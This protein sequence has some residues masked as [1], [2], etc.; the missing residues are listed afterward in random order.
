MLEAAVA[1]RDDLKEADA[2]RWADGYAFPKSLLTN[3]ASCLRS[4][5]LDFTTMVARRQK[6]MAS[7]RLNLSRATRLRDDNPA[8]A[9]MI[10]L[11]DGMKVHLP[12]H[13]VPNG[14]TDLS[15]LR[16]SYLSV[17]P[18]VNKILG[19]IVEQGLAILLSYDSAI[20]YVPRL[21]FCKAHWTP[22]KGKPS[23]R[24]LGDL[25]FVEGTP[26]NTPETAA[27][28]A[29]H[30]GEIVHPTIDQ[31]AA[32]ITNYFDSARRKCPD[33]TWERLLIWKMDLRGAYQLL[34]FHPS[35]VGLFAMRLSNDLV[36]L[37][38]VGIFGWAG[39]PA[40]FQ[41]VTRAVEWELASRLHGRATMY[42]DD[43][44]GVSLDTD[45][46]QDLQITRSVCTDLLGPEAVADDKTETGRRLDV[47]GYVIDLDLRRVSIARKNYLTALHGFLS[48]D[49][50]G[51]M[52]LRSAQ[53]LASWGS[54]Y[55]RICRVMRPFS[56]AL[57][58][59]TVGRTSPHASFK[60]SAE[61]RVTIQCWRALLC[62]IRQDEA[63]FTR[64]IFSFSPV[65]A[66]IVAEFDASLSGIGV[67]W[68]TVSQGAEETVGVC[69]LSTAFLQFAEDSSYQNLSEFLGA[70]IAVVGLVRLGCR[71]HSLKL[72][73]DSVTALT[74]AITERP[75]GVLVTN[76]AMAW[77]LLCV[78][79]EI[80]V[81]EIIHL[82]GALNQKCDRLSRM[83]CYEESSIN[84]E[85]SEMGLSGARI[86]PMQT[87]PAVQ[88]LLQC[89]DPSIATGT[90]A[91]F[92]SL[93]GRMRAAVTGVLHVPPSL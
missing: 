45:V 47:L 61:A 92:M 22:K 76:A 82:P 64:D 54:R 57:H 37:Q 32:M 30:Y 25:T 74:W 80:H 31:I 79:A 46:E 39:T 9:L 3:D 68:S 70:L 15:P 34:S 23:G 5:M 51:S 24:P 67:I 73:G 69:A 87:D 42:V 86:V 41:V 78:A 14:L 21:H 77:T 33:V 71:G 27:A 12:E 72:R 40:A 55:S 50:D 10:E 59:L 1:N 2:I 44:I 83:L 17:A 18:A 53:R 28:A 13:F 38:T 11:C 58:R 36:Y 66:T 20:R 19:A 63:Q 88:E 48:V 29:A 4:A 85:L 65:P 26:L 56:G 90:D 62:L 16:P 84:K 35:D 7:N 52:T 93:W 75:R 49:L 6:S 81:T 89:C 60:L 8:K 43:V 91:E